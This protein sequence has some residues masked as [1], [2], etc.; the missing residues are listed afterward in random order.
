VAKFYGH[1]V[2][3]NTFEP[4]LATGVIF[5][6]RCIARSI[7]IVTETLLALTDNLCITTSVFGQTHS[8]MN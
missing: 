8:S 3:G 1:T 5:S 7:P 2:V 4:T 6:P